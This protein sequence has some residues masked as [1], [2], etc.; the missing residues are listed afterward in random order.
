MVDGDEFR[1]RLEFPSRR[2]IL[3][4]MSFDKDCVVSPIDRDVVKLSSQVSQDATEYA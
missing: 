4:P 3:G 1:E 2:Y